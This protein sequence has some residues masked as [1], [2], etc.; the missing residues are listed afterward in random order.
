MKHLLF[1]LILFC[2]FQGFGQIKGYWQMNGN[3]N[4]ASGNGN[5]GT[6][7]SITFDNIQGAIGTGTQY[8]KI[9]YSISLSSNGSHTINCLV[10]ISSFPATNDGQNIFVKGSDYPTFGWGMRIVLTNISGTNYFMTDVVTTSPSAANYAATGFTPE[11][12]KWYM[13]TGIFDNSAKK[14]K[15]Y[16]DSKFITETSTGSTLRNANAS[17][18]FCIIP[19]TNVP[20]G[21]FKGA[22]RKVLIEP[23]AWN[24][25][26]LKNE[27]ASIKGLFT[28]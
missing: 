19:N 20:A 5:N 11:L 12:N 22:I 17:T 2:S 4:D 26:K 14:I 27:F 25:A 15:L 6:S 8:I 13:V 16:V 24:N 23:S 28:L 10:K 21:M 9:P 1:I 3:A 7:Y 18:I